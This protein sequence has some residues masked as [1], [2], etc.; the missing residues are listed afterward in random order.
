MNEYL[1]Y[2]EGNRETAYIV[3]AGCSPFN[4]AHTIIRSEYFDT[5][6][7]SNENIFVVENLLTGEKHRY[8]V[9]SAMVPVHDI[10]E[11]KK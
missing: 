11:I 3:N 6:G 5:Y 7:L 1:I 10:R 9:F 8:S 4:A 2:R